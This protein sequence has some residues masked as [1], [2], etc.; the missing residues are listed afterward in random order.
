MAANK[1]KSNNKPDKAALAEKNEKITN[2]L[3]IQFAYTLIISVL[4]VFEFNATG[5]YKYGQNTY[6]AARVTSWILFVVFIF[7]GIF[8]IFRKK[9]TKKP[10]FKTLS[11]YSFITAIIMFWYVGAEKIPYYFKNYIPILD[12]VSGTY[13][14][15]FLMFPLLAAAVIAEFAVY[16]IRYYMIN[17]KRK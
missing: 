17:I 16:F 12:K 5:I 4:T 10:V 3:L 14:I 9:I 8:F 1:L 11:I 15:I 6:N 7:M 13:K 2:D